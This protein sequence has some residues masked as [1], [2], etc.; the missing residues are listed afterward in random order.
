MCEKTAIHRQHDYP[1]VRGLTG[2][3]INIILDPLMIFGIG[4]FPE[5]GVYGAAAAT[6]IGQ[7]FGMLI[8]AVGR[9]YPPKVLRIKI[10]EFKWRLETVKTFTVSACQGIVMQSVVSVMTAGMNAILISFSQT[11]VNVLAV[12]FKL[13]RHSC[14]MPVFGLNQGA[15]PVMGYNYG[16][17]NKGRL[18]GAYKIALTAAVVIMGLGLVVFRAIPETM[19]MMFVDRTDAAA[20]AGDARGR[21]SGAQDH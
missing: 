7:V 8:R 9:L 2:A 21:R 6:V 1:D 16:A 11:A 14:F 19:L 10:R 17:R 4:P 12:Y 15:L 18:F 3:I 13:S 5:M 20:R